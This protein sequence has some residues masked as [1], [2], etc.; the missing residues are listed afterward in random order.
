MTEYFTRM[1][2]GTKLFMTKQQIRDDIDIATADAADAAG[3]P[4]MTENDID[5]LI[6]IICDKNRCVSVEPGREVVFSEDGGP[7]KLI[8]DSGS[9]NTGID[10]SNLNATLVLERALCHDS[11]QLGEHDYSIKAIKPLLPY[12]MWVMEQISKMTIVPYL[13]GCM[14]NMGLYYAPDGPHG[15]P[16]DLLREFKIEEAME[17]SVN[18]AAQLTQDIEYV[19]CGMLSAGAE[20]FNFDTTAS[21]GDADFYGTLKG[22]ERLR[23]AYPNAYIEMGMSSETV[24]GIHGGLEYDGEIVAGMYPHQQV[25]VAK[26]AGVNV[27]GPVVNT[28]TGK[29]LAWNIARSVTFVKECSK[30][31]EIPIH[32]NQ[33]MG[34]GGVP[35]AECPPIDAVTRAS[36]A[37]VE[38]A[39]VD[40]I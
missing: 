27:F 14:P 39:N 34:V 17:A 19:S 3:I 30:V 12:K 5:A 29:S 6:D 24:L 15:N 31:A 40:G 36:K 2:D 22:I 23:A 4:A 1:G 32:V 26:K 21:A 18:A 9:C 38:L 33:G 11:F 35:M 25:K 37:L 8:T 20:G 16:A 28:N 13:F 7:D 10:M